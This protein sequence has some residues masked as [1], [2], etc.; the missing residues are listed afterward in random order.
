VIAAVEHCVGSPAVL[1]ELKHKPGRRLTLRA[2]GPRGTAIVKLYRSDRAA[3]VADRI[4]E[5][6]EGP[7]EP[8]VPH[9]LL[10][11]P[12]KRL[13]VLSDVPGR[14]LR[15]AV[16]AG[17][18]SRCRRAGTAIGAWHRYWAGTKPA[19]LRE[20][21]V[22]LEIDALLDRSSLAPRSI[23]LQIAAALP[24]L[25]ESWRATTVVHRDLYEEQVLLD[26]RVGLVDLDDAAWGPPELDVG[27]LLAHLDL[28]ALRAGRSLA[29]SET[30]FLAGYAAAGSLDVG[31]LARCRLLAQLRLACIHLEPRL[32]AASTVLGASAR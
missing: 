21:T 28:L 18:E 22:D 2:R 29:S 24:E 1:E 3:V 13:L 9:V 31:L 5:I 23:S 8:E 32:L 30:A 25:R 15:R 14:P 11:E 7:A 20:Q 4:S 26:E 16:L 12:A 17:D 10:L 6:A 19:A 27:N